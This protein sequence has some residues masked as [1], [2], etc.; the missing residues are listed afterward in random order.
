MTPVNLVNPELVDRS[1]PILEQGLNIGTYRAVWDTGAMRT[2]LSERVVDELRLTVTGYERLASVG[3]VRDATEHFVDIYLPNR[4]GV[5][6]TPILKGDLPGKTDVLIG[7]D[8]ITLGDF[9]VTN[10][11]DKTV[12]SFRFPSVRTIDFVKEDQPSRNSPCPCGSK[13]KFKHCHGKET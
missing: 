13:K 10:F 2:V 3:A 7:M 12:M 1:K 9:A 6:D 5:I 8:I 4:L 11:G